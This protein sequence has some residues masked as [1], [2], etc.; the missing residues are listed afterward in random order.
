MFAGVYPLSTKS[1]NRH[2]TFRS[3]YLVSFRG[4]VALERLSCDK[5]DPPTSVKHTANQL[6]LS[7]GAGADAHKYVRIRVS[8]LAVSSYPSIGTAHA[9]GRSTTL[10]FPYQD[11]RR[12]PG[13]RAPSRHL[14]HTSRSVLR[15]RGILLRLVVCRTSRT[16]RARSTSSPL[17]R[18]MRLTRPCCSCRYRTRA[19]CSRAMSV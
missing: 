19:R 4:Y 16:R 2:R 12:V 15:L 18:R 14:K 9:I 8:A 5:H 3:S 17:S 7:P 6:V 1:P 13:L 11:A 10:S